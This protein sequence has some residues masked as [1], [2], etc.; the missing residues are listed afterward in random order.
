MVVDFNAT[1]TLFPIV[2]NMEW[3]CLITSPLDGTARHG[4]EFSVAM[5]VFGVP[6]R[7]GQNSVGGVLGLKAGQ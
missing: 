5:G 1:R 6:K 3:R 2:D 7:S 4:L